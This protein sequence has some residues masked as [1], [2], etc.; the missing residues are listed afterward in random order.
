MRSIYQLE[1]QHLDVDSKIAAA[2]ERLSQGFR[3]LL[4][5]KTKKLNISPIQIQ[6]LVFLFFHHK[7]QASISQLSREFGLTPATVSD[8]IATLQKKELVTRTPLA[9]D[10]RVV[11]VHLTADGKKMARRLSTWSN[12]IYENIATLQVED[13]AAVL[14]FLMLLINSLNE[15]GV[16]PVNRMCVSCRYFR[17]NQSS[18]TQQPYFCDLIQKP[19]ANATLR[20]DCPEHEA[21]T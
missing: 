12:A 21:S 8:A 18:Q 13:K 10:R 1:H 20:F 3:S 5:E 17:T 11:L 16:I 14:N 6:M 2:L 19:L 4:W 15:A 7:T 9:T